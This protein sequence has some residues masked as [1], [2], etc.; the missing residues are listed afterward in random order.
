MLVS[1]ILTLS[2]SNWKHANLTCVELDLFCCFFPAG[3]TGRATPIKL[4]TKSQLD[5]SPLGGGCEYHRIM[6]EPIGE[7]LAVT[8]TVR[9]RH[10]TSGWFL[11]YVAIS[12]VDGSTSSIEDSTMFNIEGAGIRYFHCHSVI[13]SK[14]TLAPGEGRSRLLTLG[15]LAATGYYCGGITH[16]WENDGCT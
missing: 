8:V 7:I 15:T 13:Q 5:N 12:H 16:F 1:A 14:V 4:D 11:K 10:L 6:T 9:Q 2:V 3:T